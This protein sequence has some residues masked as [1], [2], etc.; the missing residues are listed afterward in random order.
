MKRK[1]KIAVIGGGLA[2]LSAAYYLL[3]KNKGKIDLALFESNNYLGGRTKTVTVR[4][5]PIDIGGF[6]IFDWYKYLYQFARDLGVEKKIL[7]FKNFR[8]FY[9][10][11]NTGR[12]IEDKKLPFSYALGDLWLMIRSLSKIIRGELNFYNPNLH[13][14][15]SESAREYLEK[16]LGKGHKN[17]HLYNILATSYT[18]PEIDKIPANILARVLQQLRTH[19][20]FDNCHAFKGGMKILI[21]A[22]AK[23]IV[24]NGGQIFLNS[25]VSGVYG[26][27]LS[28]GRKKYEADTVIFASTLSDTLQGSVVDN[29][30]FDYTHHYTVVVEMQKDFVLN[31]YKEWLVVYTYPNDRE[32]NIVSFGLPSSFTKISSRFLLANIYVPDKQK[33]SFS[34]HG[35][36]KILGQGLAKYMPGNTIKKMHATQYWEK[37][38]PLLQMDAIKKIHAAQGVHDYYFA[39]DYTGCP[40]METAV[41]SGYSVAK[42]ICKVL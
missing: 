4:G 2:G 18:Y 42:K 15:T 3:K 38:M 16:V 40:S 7:P 31:G 1:K 23:A 29:L 36:R 10:I 13:H 26:D 34:S 6:M 30:A 19:R 8:E 37:T 5:V 11:E 27:T 20:M 12:L 35:L 41:Y 32:P 28:I 25:P 24:K 22:A 9:E 21:D 39:G 14:V 17:I 33:D